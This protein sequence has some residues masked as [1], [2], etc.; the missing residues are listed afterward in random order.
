MTLLNK[1]ILY[2]RAGTLP[3]GNSAPTIPGE[4]A[5][6]TWNLSVLKAT[7]GKPTFRTSQTEEPDAAPPV[8]ICQGIGR[9]DYRIARCPLGKKL[10]VDQEWIRPFKSECGPR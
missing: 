1:A 9:K 10:A 4:V 2:I 5:A 6:A 8:R 3:T 7:K